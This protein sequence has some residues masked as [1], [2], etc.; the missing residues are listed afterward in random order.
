MYSIQCI[1]TYIG[2]ITCVCRLH[3]YIYIVNVFKHYEVESYGVLLDSSY[4]AS[5]ALLQ[6]L[7]ARYANIRRRGWRALSDIG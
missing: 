3:I 7:R 1:S 5:R 6:R 2:Y 4:R